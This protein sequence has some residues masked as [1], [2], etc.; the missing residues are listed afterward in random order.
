MSVPAGSEMLIGA[1]AEAP[2]EELVRELRSA[3]A[4]HPEI[5]SAFLFQFMIL[6]QGEE[7]HVTLGLDLDDG[8]D[9]NEIGN[10]LAPRAFEFL[11]EG[12]DF[13][14]YPLAE[15]MREAVAQSVEPFYER[16]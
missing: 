3:A 1:P 15:D 10:D 4:A 2:P 5:R 14:V 6:A 11:P 8:A 9:L 13:D 7:P 16:S 12:S